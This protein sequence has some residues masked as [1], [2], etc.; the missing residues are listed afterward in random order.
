MLYHYSQIYALYKLL[1]VIYYSYGKESYLYTFLIHWGILI[2][3]K[4]RREQ[5]HEIVKDICQLISVY[6]FYFSYC[7]L[8]LL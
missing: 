7:E 2:V 1:Q 6:L 5:Q 4:G 3:I 8:G